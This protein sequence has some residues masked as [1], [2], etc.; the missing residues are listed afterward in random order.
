MSCSFLEKPVQELRSSNVPQQTSFWANLKSRQGIRPLA[1]H[2]EADERLL[3]VNADGNKATEDILVLLQYTH[4]DHCVAY[5]PYGPKLE[6]DAENHG[7]FLEE[8]SEVLKEH[9][10]AECFLIRYD[11]PWENQWSREEDYYNEEGQ[12]MGPPESRSQEFRLNFNTENWN[13]VKCQ[14]DNLPV[15]T[16]F[17]DLHKSEE[18]LLKRMK[19]KTRYNVRVSQRKGVEVRSYGEEQLDT[20]YDLYRETARRNGITLH[21]KEGF[22]QVFE[23]EK[24]SCV[25]VSLLIAEHEG[26]PLAAMFL[27]LSRNRGTY[28]FGATSGQK[29]NLMASYAVQWEGIK[30]AKAHGCTEY[31]MFGTAPNNDPQ[32]PMYG[33]YRFKNGFGGEMHHRMGCWDYPLDQ[34][35]YTIFRARETMAQSY[36]VN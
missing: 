25:D 18:Q 28:L 24:Q 22:E 2:Y 36:H 12:W 4:K 30:K 11:L 19:A 13:L 27:L 20:W 5:V 34:K 31:D 6:P 14:S 7:Y 33:L 9:L 32:H 35:R 1:F 29:R 16:F 8:F 21:G 26:D 15:N 10:P 23:S 3:K 17:L